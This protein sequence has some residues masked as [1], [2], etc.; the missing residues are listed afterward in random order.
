MEG[1]K[2]AN[3]L[4]LNSSMKSTRI[5]FHLPA[6]VPSKTS[7]ADQEIVRAAWPRLVLCSA[8]HITASVFIN[9]NESGL[10]RKL[11]VAETP[12][13]RPFADAMPNPHGRD[14]ADARERQIMGRK[15]WWRSR[16]GSIRAGSR[17][18][19]VRWQREAGAGQGDR[20]SGPAAACAEKLHF[21]SHSPSELILL[22]LVLI[23]FP[24]RSRCVEQDVLGVE[25]GVRS[26]PR[27]VE[28]T[29]AAE[30]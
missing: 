15:W 5:T 1:F 20:S 23:P 26:R 10:R 4:R 28:A 29:N 3:A 13:V 17:F 21:S 14:N 22:E 7:R 30:A 2:Q 6:R 24:T 18:S 11:A 12:S 25:D 9:D 27:V 19:A 16:R 8:M